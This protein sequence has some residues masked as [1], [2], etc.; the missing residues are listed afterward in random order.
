M[1]NLRLLARLS[2]TFL[3]VLTAAVAVLL[4]SMGALARGAA[5]LLGLPQVGHR[6]LLLLHSLAD[7][8]V[9]PG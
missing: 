9:E 6:G 7:S 4:P 3:V 2:V 5:A 1:D 8:I